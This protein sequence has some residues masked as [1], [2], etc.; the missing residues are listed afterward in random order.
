MTII[1]MRFRVSFVAGPHL[2]LLLV[3]VALLTFWLPVTLW[4][5]KVLLVQPTGLP[6]GLSINA[7]ATRTLI[8]AL[9]VSVA[10]LALSYPLVLLW[11]LSA[12]QWRLLILGVAI[13]PLIMGFLARNYAWIGMLSIIEQP[14]TH[15][16]ATWHILYTQLGVA[17]V[18][19][20][21]FL[22]TTFFILI[23]STAT[24]TQSQVDAARTL[25]CGEFRILVFVLAS[26]TKRG[27]LLA[28]GLVFAMSAAFFVTPRMIG[29]GKSDLMT[30]IIWSYVDIGEFGRAS[31]L[32]LV[33]LMLL[34]IPVALVTYDSIRRRIFTTGR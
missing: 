1:P 21:V 3:A 8:T 31:A 5:L 19:T 4:I 27:A 2:G 6:P 28:F 34:L 29:G 26:Q 25:G 18:M 7:V 17:A 13:L 20:V 15:V 24:M 22:P 32:A 23:E 33:F 14:G 10:S 30:N 12:P 11:R 16:G 9:Y